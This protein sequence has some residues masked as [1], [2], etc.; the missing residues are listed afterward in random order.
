[1]KKPTDALL[2][3]V[4]KSNIRTVLTSHQRQLPPILSR[5]SFL[6]LAVLVSREHDAAVLLIPTLIVLSAVNFFLQRKNIFN[7]TSEPQECREIPESRISELSV[8]WT[9]ILM[10]CYVRHGNN[11]STIHYH[12]PAI[13]DTTDIYYAPNFYHGNNPTFQHGFAVLWCFNNANICSC[14]L[15]I[16]G[17]SQASK[18]SLLRATS[19]ELDR[20]IGGTPVP[21]QRKYPWMAW[22]GRSTNVFNCGGAL[23]NDRYVL[24][25]AHCVQSNPTGTYYVSLG[26]KDLFQWPAGQAIQVSAT[27][28]MH[29]QYNP[30]TLENDMALLKLQTPVN[31]QA[32]PNI[33]PICLSSTVNPVPGSAVTISGWGRTLGSKSTV[34]RGETRAD[35]GL[36]LAETK[37]FETAFQA[38]QASRRF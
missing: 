27:A 31:F 6:Q 32:Y 38:A 13:Y 16:C 22:M 20:I 4:H 17:V 14:N 7:G 10:H 36:V 3:T 8:A 30:N 25:A 26:S 2:R 12:T 19:S 1:M 21:S 33:R 34:Y 28:I 15:R 11:S 9:G 29:P 37:R 18:R 23:I 5:I 35:N 24:T